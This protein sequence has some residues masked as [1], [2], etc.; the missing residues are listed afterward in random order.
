MLING[1]VNVYRIN[2]INIKMTKCLAISCT[3]HL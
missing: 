1:I 3:A 2:L